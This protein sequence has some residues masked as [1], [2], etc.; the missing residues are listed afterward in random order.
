MHIK[1]R[2]LT[3]SLLKA[4]K[5]FPAIVLTGP[6][7]SGKTTLLKS[8]FSS[9]H[10]FINL[11][12]PDVRMR[13][14]DD[15]A[16]FLSQYSSPLVID[17][18]QYIPE[19]L[20]YIKTR[21]D[22]KRKPGQWIMTGSQNFALMHNVTQSLAGR[23]A[24]LSLLPFSV[25]ESSGAGLNS[26]SV[27]KWLK[28]ISLK[29]LPEGKAGLLDK[30]LLR[31]FYPEI[32]ANAKVDRGLWCG[33]YITTYLERDIRQITNVGDLN[34]FERFL[35]LCAARVGQI[36]NLSDIAKDAGISVTTA[37]RWISLLEAGYQIY[38][39]YPYYRNVGKR[40]VKSPKLY[41]TDTALCAYLLGLRDKAT[42]Y[43][44]MYFGNLFENMVVCD[45]LKRFLHNGE[46]PALYYF[47]SND[48]LEVDIVFENS[49]NLNLFE[50]KSSMTIVPKHAASLKKMLHDLG[51]RIE[52]AG[53]ISCTDD[54]FSLGPGVVNYGWKN[55]LS[56]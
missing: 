12:N 20:S 32:E 17:E 22:E 30:Y 51:G 40:V 15:P 28:K 54:N 23:A 2:T 26:I 53:V 4:A 45:F 39:L 29:S 1:P 55:I 49:C 44:S 37:K 48:G 9:T 42:L 33:S 34:D 50:V 18:I 27:N 21:I 8:L 14:K 13:A 56:L 35:R 43:G 46:L 52:S 7:Q 19:L 10:K 16:G 24:V 11:E 5:T 25:S 38:L 41:F 31:G 36:L 47:R 3:G 6:R